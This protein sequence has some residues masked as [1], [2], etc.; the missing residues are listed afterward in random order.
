[1]LQD[2]KESH[3]KASRTLHGSA[4]VGR[5]DATVGQSWTQFFQ[6]CEH[7]IMSINIF[8]IFAFPS[9]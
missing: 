2:V 7:P 9:F 1:M 4:E 8:P 3:G 5:L 6:E